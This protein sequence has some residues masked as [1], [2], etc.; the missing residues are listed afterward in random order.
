MTNILISKNF[1]QF[2][3]FFK[4]GCLNRLFA[5]GIVLGFYLFSILEITVRVSC[6]LL[7]MTSLLEDRIRNTAREE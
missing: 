6:Q 3:Y 4:K 1:F 7:T 5:E 2:I